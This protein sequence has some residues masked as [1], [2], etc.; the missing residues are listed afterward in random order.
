MGSL[1]HLSQSGV[2]SVTCYETTGWQGVM[3]REAGPPAPERFHSIHGG[4]FPLYHVLADFG[5]FAGGHVVPSVSSAPLRAEG[6][7]LRKGAL[8]RI[9]VANLRPGLQNV[10]LVW[11]GLTG[12][13]CVKPLDETNAEEA[14]RSPEAFRKEPGER[15]Q[16]ADGALRLALRP[17]AVVRVDASF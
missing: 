7:A 3:E 4:A 1:K 10:R 9:L 8:A 6:M 15:M 2:Q 13:V 12:T 5:E 17:Y 11:P 16:V 14:M